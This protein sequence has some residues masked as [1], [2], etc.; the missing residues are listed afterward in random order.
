MRKQDVYIA[1]HVRIVGLGLWLEEEHTLIMADTHFGYEEMLN[2]QG[3]MVPRMNFQKITEHIQG[4]FDILGSVKHVVIAGDV[5]HEFGRISEQEWNEVIDFIRMLEK[6]AS[7]VTLIKGNHDTILGPLGRWEG[8]QIHEELYLRKSKTIVLHGHKTSDSNDYK[9]AKTIIVGHEHPAV[10]LVEG[11]RAEQYKCFLKGSYRSKTLI[12]VPAMNMVV[13]GT[14][15]L[16][17]QLISPF[18]QQSNLHE[19]ECWIVEDKPYY[20]GK[21]KHIAKH[22]YKWY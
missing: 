22:T 12:V 16:R 2:E 8:L 5:K 10:T 9:Q 18:L 19:F 17:E 15:V 11:V 20:F 6:H 7:Q 13:A 3:I 21:L 1:E 14:D 4:I